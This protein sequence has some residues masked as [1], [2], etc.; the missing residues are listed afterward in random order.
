V[1]YVLWKISWWYEDIKLEEQR[2]EE[3]ILHIKE[4]ILRDLE[5]LSFYGIHKGWEW[6]GNG[7]AR[8]IF[9]SKN[10]MYF[11]NMRKVLA[12]P[13]KERRNADS[14]K[15]MLEKDIGQNIGNL[16]GEQVFYELTDEKYQI[17]IHV[18]ETVKGFY[19]RAE[20]IELN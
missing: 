8:F 14:V 16:I 15:A 11:P 2:L 13:I 1:L 17:S 20:M 4:P 18:N 7:A 12:T 10:N 6:Q 5:I 19:I 3:L 9:Y